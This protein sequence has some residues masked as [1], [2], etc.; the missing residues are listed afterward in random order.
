MRIEY[1]FV[2]NGF[3]EH[4]TSVYICHDIYGLNHCPIGIDVSYKI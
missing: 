1:F 4:V 3:K 2:S